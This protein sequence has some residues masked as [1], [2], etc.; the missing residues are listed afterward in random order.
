MCLDSKNMLGKVREIQ[1][2]NE[3]SRVGV[4]TKNL[5]PNW[6]CVS[7][8]KEQRPKIASRYESV[9]ELRKDITATL[10]KD[11]SNSKKMDSNDDAHS[12]ASPADINEDEDS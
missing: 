4:P 9:H 8:A 5:P 2:S 10:D 6:D 12:I 11:Y 1:Y 7:K 3:P